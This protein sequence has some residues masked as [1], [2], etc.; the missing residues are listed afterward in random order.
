[1]DSGQN[2]RE[3]WARGQD[4]VAYLTR[5]DGILVGRKVSRGYRTDEALDDIHEG[6]LEDARR[7]RAME[8]HDEEER[9]DG[10][11]E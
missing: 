8:A 6:C 3:A 9:E 1:M 5:V 7:D 11:R 10:Q 2:E 4:P